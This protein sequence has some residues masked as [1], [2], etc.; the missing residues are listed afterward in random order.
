[1]ATGSDADVNSNSLEEGNSRFLSK[2][3]PSFCYC[4][5]VLCISGYSGFVNEFVP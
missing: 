1:M 2:D 3:G 5:N 4:V